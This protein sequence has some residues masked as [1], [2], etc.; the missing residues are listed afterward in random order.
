MPL[1]LHFILPSKGC[2]DT[3]STSKSKA[4]SA[5]ILINKLVVVAGEV[6]PKASP[7]GNFFREKPG[8][9]ACGERNFLAGGG[10]NQLTAG[11]QARLMK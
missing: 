7:Q 8:Q 4:T 5:N 2:G 9:R 10:F 3:E 6:E 11:L 1:H